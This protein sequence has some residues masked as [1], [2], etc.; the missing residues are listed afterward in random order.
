MSNKSRIIKFENENFTKLETFAKIDIPQFEEKENKTKGWINYASD[1]K[2]PY[3]LISLLAK[4][5]IH[6][7]ILKKKAML[8][9]GRGFI[10]TNVGTDTMFFLKNSRNSLDLEEILHRVAYDFELFGA[11]ALN[12]IW[13]KDRESI[14]EI[15]YIDPA[16]LRVAI[17]DPEKPEVESY[18]I[19]DGWENI[20]K[21]PPIKYDGFSTINRKSASQIL[22]VKDHR[23]GTEF[24][25][26]PEYLAGI[27]WMEIQIAISQF[28]LANI[29]NGFH[30]SFH[31]NWPIANNLSDEEMDV[32][33]SRLKNQFQGSI[34]AGE[35]FL[36]IQDSENAP[37]ITPIQANTSD[38]RFIQLQETIERSIL[39]SHR[40][41]N[42]ELF[43][44][45]TEG[46]LGG[47]KNERMDSMEEFE[48]DYVIPKQQILE[49]IFNKLARINGIT[50]R[51]YINKYSDQYKKIDKSTAEV[52]SIM[53][54]E[55][56]PEQKYHLLI[57]NSYTHLLASK[58]SG[59][60]EGNNQ[61]EEGNIT[62]KSGT[63][64]HTHNHKFLNIT[65][66]DGVAE[67]H[68]NCRCQIRN[69]LFITEPGCCDY[70]AEMRDDWNNNREGK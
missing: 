3:Y 36:T 19:S 6:S 12:I 9:G 18:F 57:A 13:S 69:N 20:K 1:N 59:Y 52:L 67:I 25:G 43:G 62:P 17:P 10:T 34:N 2:F 70:C 8:I 27:F 35:T 60:T 39:Q 58:L 65:E 44:I 14:S 68:P 42:P 5:P 51:L 49:K 50:D 63:Q 21:Y 48:I 4:S 30:P 33:V 37:T 55:I 46:S 53:T 54:A 45:M 28:H 38:E 41:N 61:K 23:A 31:I 66:N 26:Q 64:S 24:Y 16:K 56:T 22:Y 7:A 47:G 15:N 32:L 11:F 29:S 40:V